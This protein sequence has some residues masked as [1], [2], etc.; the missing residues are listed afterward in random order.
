MAHGPQIPRPRSAPAEPPRLEIGANDDRT[1]AF[2][3]AYRHSRTVRIMRIALPVTAV[4]LL[5]TYGISVRFTLK[6]LGAGGTLTVQAPQISGENLVMQNPEYQ[7]FGKDGSRFV[8]RSK[9]AEQDIAQKEPVKLKSIEARVL[10]TDNALTVM[11]SPSGTYDIKSGVLELMERIEI[12]GETGLK[13]RLTRATVI[14]KEGRII[15]KEP[16]LIDMPTGRVRGN[17]MEIWQKTRQ[18]AFTRGVAARLTPQNPSGGSGPKPQAAVQT[19]ALSP[20]GGP[21]DV[22]SERLDIDDAKK[23]AIFRGNVRAVQGEATL[24][25]PELAVEYTGQAVPGQPA[26]SGPAAAGADGQNG[27]LKRLVAKPDVTLTRGEEVVRTRQ[28]DFDGEREIAT[29]TGGVLITAPGGRQ[30]TGDRADMDVK[31][32]KAKLTGNVVVVSGTD[33]RVTA[34]VAEMDQKNDTALLTGST[35]NVTQGQNTLR[36]QRLYVDRKAGTMEMTSPGGR[37]AAQFVREEDAGKAA[38][39]PA[40]AASN[41]AGGGGLFGGE[42]GGFSFRA[43]PGAPINVEADQL[44]AN[45]AAK[46]AT[47]R[48]TVKATQGGF[49]IQTPE[50]V[51]T[52][53]GETGFASDPSKP[54]AAPAAKGKAA[55]KG[56]ASEVGGAQL[57]KIRANQKVLLTSS[58]GQTVEGDWAEFDTKANTAVVG[59]N[60]GNVV[61]KQGQNVLHGPRLMIDMATGKSRLEGP[62]AQTGS[63]WSAVATPTGPG[64]IGGSQAGVG[65]AAQAQAA[66]KAIGEGKCGGRM[67]AVFYPNEIQG[68]AKQKAQDVAKDPSPPQKGG[69]ETKPARAG[70]ASSWETGA[71]PVS[72]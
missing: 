34:D 55:G 21:V 70:A 57:Q 44:T 25:A 72:R 12:D 64:P 56:K 8:V 51:A 4:L 42:G 11:T 9:T 41:G 2:K 48:G 13:A 65:S 38:A 36:G 50:L 14:S 1:G 5:A 28:L 26:T 49:T 10:Q 62:N 53:S 60:S 31:N 66:A 40:A 23:T 45:D 47:F 63:G 22:T 7:G 35:V 43:E 71:G 33:Q 54:Q 18:I 67:C 29:L 27:Q 16:V 39:K 69:I 15:S 17:E 32:D 61:V 58:N 59:S 30:V 6:D 46:T 52:Y 37:I 20:S 68:A 24:V 3:S 19:S